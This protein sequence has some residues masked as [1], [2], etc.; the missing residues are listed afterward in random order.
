MLNGALKKIFSLRPQGN[1]AFISVAGDG[2]QDIENLKEDITK[3]DIS[4]LAQTFDELYGSRQVLYVMIGHLVSSAYA[5]FTPFRSHLWITGAS[6]SGKSFLMSVMKNL[7]K[8]LCLSTSNASAA[9]LMQRINEDGVAH[10]PIVLLDEAGSDTSGKAQR[11]EEIVK[12]AREAATDGDNESLRGTADQSAKV[13]KKAFSLTLASTSH[14]LEDLQDIS[15]FFILDIKDR[16]D[17][18]KVDLFKKLE[19]ISKTLHPKFLKAILTTAP[20]YEQ[21]VEAALKKLNDSEFSNSK[22]SHKR[23]TWASL[24][25]GLACIFYYFDKDTDKAIEQ[26]FKALQDQIKGDRHEQVDVLEFGRNVVYDI[27][28]CSLRIQN[29]N[30]PLLVHLKQKNNQEEML[31]KY[32]ISLRQGKTG[33]QLVLD[34]KMKG[35]NRLFKDRNKVLTPLINVEAALKDLAARD[36]I[37]DS[38][39]KH[40]GT[41]KSVRCFSIE[42]PQDIINLYK[43]EN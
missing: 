36:V 19:E 7:V 35:Y 41:N 21:L 31:V 16:V 40:P 4:D 39:Y 6:G 28:D 38:V 34:K 2:T 18:T 8:G 24:I 30:I 14:S 17:I 26:A 43:L 1:K 42:I 3:E 25:A 10:S 5:A 9:G 20:H 33:L 23:R 22:E 13:Y 32:G 12:I 37:K 11:M 27:F 29:L 15:R